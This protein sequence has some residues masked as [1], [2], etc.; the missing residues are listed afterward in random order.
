VA[1]LETS[2]SDP[3]GMVPCHLGEFNQVILNLLVNAAHAIAA[4]VGDGSKGKGKIA[5]RTTR[6]Q[7]WAQISIQDTGCGIQRRFSPTSVI[8]FSPPRNQER[9]LARDWP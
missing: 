1:D 3:V 5:I 9:A 2:L 4:V 8:L 7:N 6:E